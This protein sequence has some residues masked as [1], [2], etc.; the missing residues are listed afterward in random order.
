M[1]LADIVIFGAGNMAEMANVYIE[2]HSDDRIVGFTVDAAYKNGD[3]FCGRPLVAW[4]ELE[5]HFPPTQVKLLGPLTPKK[6][7]S[8]RRDRFYEGLERNY[9]FTSFVHPFNCI[10]AERIGRNCVILENN[11]IQP[12]A[13]IG[14]NVIIWS[15]NVIGHH[16]SI[17]DHCFMS[18]QSGIAGGS[19]IG[20][21]C[22]IGAQVGIGPGITIGARCVLVNGAGVDRDLPD[23]TVILG[24]VGY[25]GVVRP[26]PSS[27]IRHLL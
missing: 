3:S 6:I 24:H 7:N 22:F 17:G 20:E 11:V 12:L 25:R 1:P 27:R 14:D 19:K 5:E 26:F 8:I 4:E 18:S 9:E 16:V 13:E 15:G 10:Y 23:E 21:E 2:R